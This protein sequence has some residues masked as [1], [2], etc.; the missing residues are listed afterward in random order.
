[1]AYIRHCGS[2]AD[3]CGTFRRHRRDCAPKPEERVPLYRPGRSAADTVS[4]I[5]VRKSKP[6]ACQPGVQVR[7]GAMVK[8]IN[9]DGLTTESEEGAD[10]IAAKTVVWAGGITAS[11][12]GRIL[13]SC[14]N[15][16]TDKEGSVKVKPDLTIPNC[17]DIYVI[18]DLASATVKQGKPLP[19]LAQVA[20]QGGQYAATAIPRRRKG[21]QKLPPFHYFDQGSPAVIGRAA[22]VADVFGAQHSG[23]VAMAGMGL[24]SP[25]VLGDFSKPC[26]SLYS[27]G[28]PG[29]DIQPWSPMNHRRCSDRLQFHQRAVGTG[30]C[31]RDQT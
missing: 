18:G 29:S 15:A 9:K 20:M 8:H 5:P 28:N 23:F 6:F 14:T 25:F 19:G 12:L 3:R 22:T 27:M 2:R 26:S 16:E 4:G 7:C 24:H 1:M 13:A 31:A 17:P 11:P 10:S 21:Q 30:R